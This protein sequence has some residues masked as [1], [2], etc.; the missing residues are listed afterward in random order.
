MDSIPEPYH[1]G[2]NERGEDALHVDP[3]LC[4]AAILVDCRQVQVS[5]ESNIEV[6]LAVIID[7]DTNI[8]QVLWDRL[9]DYYYYRSGSLDPTHIIMIKG[10]HFEYRDRIALISVLVRVV[11]PAVQVSGLQTA[12][13]VFPLVN[14]ILLV[15]V[16]QSQVETQL[17]I[18]LVVS[19]LIVGDVGLQD[20]DESLLPPRIVQIHAV[21]R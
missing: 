18:G 14:W 17:C 13:E 9:Q 20:P 10:S 4:E 16:R 8:E 11:G 6:H 19:Q 2:N 5:Y 15:P 1:D 3:D 21:A 12:R 7:R